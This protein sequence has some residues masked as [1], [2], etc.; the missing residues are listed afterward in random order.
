MVPLTHA[1]TLTTPSLLRQ[2]CWKLGSAWGHFNTRPAMWGFDASAQLSGAGTPPPKPLP[3]VLGSTKVVDC[4]EGPCVLGPLVF[5]PMLCRDFPAL[6][7]RQSANASLL[8]QT[9]HL[10]TFPWNHSQCWRTTWSHSIAL[11]RPTQLSPSTGEC[12]GYR[13]LPAH[14]NLHHVAATWGVT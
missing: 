2:F 8:L 4:P 5:P 13:A 14:P 6:F 3:R 9:P 12:H 1:P 7:S 11:P 10:L